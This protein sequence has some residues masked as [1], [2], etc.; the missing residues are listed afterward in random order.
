MSNVNINRTGSDPS[1][2]VHYNYN[3]PRTDY[4]GITLLLIGIIG[5]LTIV[6][7]VILGMASI[8]CYFDSDYECV[9]RDYIFWGYI[10]IITLA[11]IPALA[12]AVMIVWERTFNMRYLQWRGVMTHRNDLREYAPAIID[13]ARVS[14]ES[15]ATAGLDTYSPSRTTASKP[16]LK[17]TAD[18]K[19]IEGAG[20]DDDVNMLPISLGDL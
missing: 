3:I 2:N 10:I 16:E 4:K 18:S 5:A 1:D 15:E 7:L 14:A 8:S 20:N 6:W 11:L 13:V 12:A 17:L 9:A 19:L